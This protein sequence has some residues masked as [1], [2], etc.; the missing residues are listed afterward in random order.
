MII[1]KSLSF[2]Y[3]RKAKKGEKKTSENK[4]K[5]VENYERTYTRKQSSQTEL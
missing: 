3:E 4:K 2:F 1:L 5:D